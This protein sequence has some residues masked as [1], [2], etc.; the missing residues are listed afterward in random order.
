ME[1]NII[2]ET[3]AFRTPESL[4]AARELA[5]IML[6]SVEDIMD[7]IADELGHDVFQGGTLPALSFI[8]EA[9]LRNLADVATLDDV[10]EAVADMETYYGVQ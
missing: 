8:L 1:T 4:D 5:S 7:P 6:A 3:K 2:E 9:S 10:A